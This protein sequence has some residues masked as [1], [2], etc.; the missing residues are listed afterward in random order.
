MTSLSVRKQK[1]HKRRRSVWM[2][3]STK[4]WTLTAVRFLLPIESQRWL[5]LTTTLIVH[6]VNQVVI[7]LIMM[8]KI[9]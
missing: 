4:C 9:P 1:V 5:L 3:G 8:M 7:V 2:D 6:S